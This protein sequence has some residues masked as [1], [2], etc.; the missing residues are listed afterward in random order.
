M[1]KIIFL[2]LAA[3]LTICSCDEPIGKWDDN[4]KLSQKNVELKGTEDSVIITTKGD[5]WW[6]NSILFDGS[7]FFCDAIGSNGLSYKIQED[8][9]IIEKRDKNTL[10]I[11]L[12]ENETEA[13]RTMTITLQAGNY[14]DYINIKQSAK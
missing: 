2:F 9:F 1:K 3:T 14:F 5:S 6:L 4:I 8:D 11:K 13:V 12:S 10:F 7:W